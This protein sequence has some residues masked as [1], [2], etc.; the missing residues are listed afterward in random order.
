[1]CEFCPTNL[2]LNPHANLGRQ[3]LILVEEA[4]V[5]DGMSVDLVHVAHEG[6]TRWAIDPGRDC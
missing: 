2:Q 4:R 6:G 5:V 1:M 3:G